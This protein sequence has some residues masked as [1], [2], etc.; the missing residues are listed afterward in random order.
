MSMQNLKPKI[1]DLVRYIDDEAI[2]IL[3]IARHGIVKSVYGDGDILSVMTCGRYF[4]DREESF[5]VASA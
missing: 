5:Q 1:G 4:I 3:G 2:E